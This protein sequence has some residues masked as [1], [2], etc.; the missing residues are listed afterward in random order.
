[1][2]QKIKSMVAMLIL[3]YTSVSALAQKTETSNQTFSLEIDPITYAANGYSLHLRVKPKFSQ[4][5][6]MGIGA[7]AMDMPGF[8]VD[9]NKSNQSKGW[10]VRLNQGY[11]LFTEY[12]FSRTNHKFF[13]GGQTSIQQYRIALQEHTGS[14]NFTNVLL[15]GY[16]G[17]TLQPFHFP[18]YFKFWA[19]LGYNSKISGHN[20][21]QNQE[22]EISPL[23]MFGTLHVGYTFSKSR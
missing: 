8:M 23:A 4:Q 3:S 10:N 16:G 11:G 13:I 6:L 14:E 22:Y 21:V 7:Y 15:M 20:V 17:Y 2:K 9:L 19:G 5:L 1:M 12:F 18:L